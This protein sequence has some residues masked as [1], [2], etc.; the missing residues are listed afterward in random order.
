MSAPSEAETSTTSDVLHEWEKSKENV[1]PQK[2]G[3]KAEDIRRAFQ[4]TQESSD[5]RDRIKKFFLSFLLFLCKI[6]TQFREFETTIAELEEGEQ[7]MRA[8][9]RCYFVLLYLSLRSGLSP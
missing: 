9:F 2:G 4:E 3:R 8:W 6:H 1:L 7:L 5:S